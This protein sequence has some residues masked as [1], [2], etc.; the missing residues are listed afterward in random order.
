MAR[1]IEKNLYEGETLL[2]Q[3]QYHWLSWARAWAVL[4]VLGIILF[5][6]YFFIAEMIRLN[7]TEFAVTDRRVV[8]KKG[9]WSADVQEISLDAIEGSALK[10]SVLG[11][12]FGFGRLSI[13]G[14]GETHIPFPTMAHP[15]EFRAH[16]ERSRQAATLS[17]KAEAGKI[18]TGET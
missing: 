18:E 10:Q 7:T 16:A 3:G 5:G 17:G 6:I 9:L 13:H 12:M 15:R 2:Y 1:Y 14:R 11:R 4:L 8:L